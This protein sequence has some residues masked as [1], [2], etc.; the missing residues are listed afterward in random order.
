M[1]KWPPA[2]VA[3]LAERRVV[4]FLGAGVSAAAVPELPSWTEL[5]REISSELE[6]AK[7]KKLLKSLVSKQ[8]LLDAAEL[9]SSLKSATERRA[10]FERKFKFVPVP[11]ISFYEDILSLDAKVCITTNYDQLIE[12]NFEYAGGGSGSHQVRD[13]MY[14]NFLSDLRSSSRV[15]LKLH[16]CITNP[17]SIVLDKRS[18]FDA[19]AKYGGIYEAVVA[20]STVNTVLFLGYSINDPD[21]QLV[22]ENVNL[23]MKTDH[24][25]YALVPKFEHPS[26]REAAAHTYNIDFIEYPRGEHSQ[27]PLALKKLR[28][29]VEE[30]RAGT[31]TRL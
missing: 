11:K 30:H 23:K 6:K 16:G 2:L 19:R 13:Y 25:H 15:I 17:G 26:L 12:K 8:R 27:F 5:L 1:V 31:G 9:V 24:P 7:D 4:L 3:E 20:L 18:Y 28:Q 22:L 21:I 29:E 14:N 10:F